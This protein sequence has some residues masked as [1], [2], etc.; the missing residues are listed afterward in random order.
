M[1]FRIGGLEPDRVEPPCGLMADELAECGVKRRRVDA[2]PGCPDRIE[3]REA[4]PREHV[5]LLDHAHLDV[6][7][8]Y[9]ASHAIVS[10]KGATRRL[11]RIDEAP[12][13]AL[14]SPGAKLD[15]DARCAVRWRGRSNRR[16]CSSTRRHRCGQFCECLAILHSAASSP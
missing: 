4:Q 12:R 3:L 16:G 15:R 5:L 8:P 6:D 9:R 2:G 13:A 11:D 7:P 10:R 1:H 14:R